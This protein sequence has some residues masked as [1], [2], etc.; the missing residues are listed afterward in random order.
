MHDLIKE[1]QANITVLQGR[2][3]EIQEGMKGLRG[4]AYFAAKRRIAAIDEELGDL[5]FALRL[6]V[7]L[8]E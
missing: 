8:K 2:R 3:E 4:E 6:M 7:K 1:Y 5:A